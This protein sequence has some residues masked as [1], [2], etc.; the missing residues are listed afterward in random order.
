MAAIMS[1]LPL[2]YACTGTN[3][4][5]EFHSFPQSKW[6]QSEII[7]LE[8][9]VADVS[10]HYDVYLEIRNNNQYSFR[11]LWLFIDVKMADG[12]VR[13]DTI[14]IPLADIYGKWFG[15]GI[16]TYSLA[17]LYK[18]DFQYPE[19]GTYVYTIRQGMRS[20]VLNGISEVGLRIE[21]QYLLHSEH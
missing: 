16:G 7:R 10:K 19:A 4:F 15:T 12:T 9:P 13:N 5:S 17:Y 21:T 14:S 20:E 3:F 2:V 11:N 8:V 6:N 1:F 18:S